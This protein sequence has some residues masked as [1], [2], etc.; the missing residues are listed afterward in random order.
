MASVHCFCLT[1]NEF[2][3]TTLK[4]QKNV[5][6][7]D[8]ILPDHR[9]GFNFFNV[10]SDSDVKDAKISQRLILNPKKQYLIR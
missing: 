1:L 4:C 7:I 8:E 6:D 2:L 9:V 3:S 5:A 10:I